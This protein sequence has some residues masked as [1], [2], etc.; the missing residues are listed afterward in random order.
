MQGIKITHI[1][2]EQPLN[3]DEELTSYRGSFAFR[4]GVKGG[5]L[6]P[7][8]KKYVEIHPYINF[9]KLLRKQDH[10]LQ[11]FLNLQR[12]LDFQ[13]ILELF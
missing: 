13:T 4:Q 10:F 9:K 2:H 5:A 1:S 6:T 8:G 7:R 12:D 3:L 11:H